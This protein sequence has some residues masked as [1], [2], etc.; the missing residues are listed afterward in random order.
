[1]GSKY[2]A[3]SKQVSEKLGLHHVLQNRDQ[4]MQRFPYLDI[5]ENN[6]GVLQLTKGGMVNPRKLVLALKTA[7]DLQGCDIFENIAEEIF[8]KNIPDKGRILEVQLED[9]QQILA[10]KVLLCTNT[11]TNFKNLLPAHLQLDIG[12]MSSQTLRIEL[13]PEDVQRFSNM[14]A[15]SSLAEEPTDSDCYACPPV[16]YPDGKT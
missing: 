1:M 13:S 10:R 11:F 14:P 6:E 9:G 12:L 7:A 4:L 5:G 2:V 3:K 8:H 15:M 16:V